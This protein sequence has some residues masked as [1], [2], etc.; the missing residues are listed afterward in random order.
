ME[1]LI[2]AVAE[3]EAYGSLEEFVDKLNEAKQLFD[4]EEDK[5]TYI[6]LYQMEESLEYFRECLS[7]ALSF[8]LHETL[9][10]HINTKSQ[11]GIQT[12]EAIISNPKANM[13]SNLATVR[14]NHSSVIIQLNVISSP[15][16]LQEIE[17]LKEYVT[18]QKISL[19]RTNNSAIKEAE[20]IK[21]QNTELLSEID[22]LRTI[23]EEERKNFKDSAS[24]ILLTLQR[25]SSKEIFDF[26][27]KEKQDFKDQSESI[28]SQENEVMNSLL[29]KETKAEE[30]LNLSSKAALAGSYRKNADYE[31]NISWVWSGIAIGSVAGAVIFSIIELLELDLNVT[32][33]IARLAILSAIFSV[34]VY[35]T[36]QATH[37][38]ELS[39]ENR[40][41]ELELTTL[42]P[43]I[44]DLPQDERQAIQK[45]L[46]YKYFGGED[47]TTHENEET[48]N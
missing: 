18:K 15:S 22:Q 43:F 28:L 35:A 32:S 30:I 40:S 34:F 23:I 6:N 11:K 10:T 1:E 8:L 26:I 2:E 3:H 17:S 37:H 31:R 27:E 46:A 5:E 24:D 4:K 19:S 47:I 12:L 14:S 25:E 48:S 16:S 7:N 39:K 13:S 33:L 20:E 38:R 36:K 9:L 41:R 29:S 45:K 21:S 44:N 42:V